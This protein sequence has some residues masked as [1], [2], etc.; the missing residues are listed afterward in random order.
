MLFYGNAETRLQKEY[1][2]PDK[3][4]SFAISVCSRIYIDTGPPIV[5]I[6]N[7]SQRDRNEKYLKK[8]IMKRT[9]T[10]MHLWE[11]S[12]NCIA[13]GVVQFAYKI[14]ERKYLLVTTN[15]RTKF[16]NDTIL[17]I[18][19]WLTNYWILKFLLYEKERMWLIVYFHVNFV[20]DKS[21]RMIK[22]TSL[23]I[24]K[25]C[26]KSDVSRFC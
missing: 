16:N 12:R 1:R 3:S 8:C 24:K 4:T 6:Q 5:K 11:V 9:R 23:K 20:Y 26:L 10:F 15:T 25:I 2:W 18:R 21:S 7:F 22:S 14:P 13:H 19:D 17:V